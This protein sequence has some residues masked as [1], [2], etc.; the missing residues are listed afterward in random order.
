MTATKPAPPPTRPVE[1][2]PEP[3]RRAIEALAVDEADDRVRGV[4]LALVEGDRRERQQ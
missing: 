3:L 4:L 2:D 1:A